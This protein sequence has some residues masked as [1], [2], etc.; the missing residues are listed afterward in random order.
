VHVVHVVTALSPDNGFGGPA[1][2][3][4]DLA[5]GAQAAGHDV[6]VIAAAVGYDTLPTSVQG[7]P[8]AL[9]RGFNPT[10]VLGWASLVAP[11]LPRL[12]RRQLPGA[13]VVHVHLA[14]DVVTLTGALA[15]RRAHVPYL[16]QTHGMIDAAGGRLA[17]AVDAIATR[18][19]V[20]GAREA[21]VLTGDEQAE[22]HALGLPEARIFRFPNG[23]GPP[24]APRSDPASGPVLFLARLH[25]RKGAAAFARAAVRLA[26]LEPGTRFAII[27]PNEG[28]GAAVDRELD[29]ASPEVRARIERIGGVP[30]EEARLRLAEALVYVLPA[31]AEPFGMTVIEAM[32][33]GRPV[34]LAQ[35]SELAPAVRD[36]GAGWTFG[37]AGDHPDLETALGAVLRD[38]GA[39]EQAG[40]RAAA[41]VTERFRIDAVVDQLLEHYEQIVRRP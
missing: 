10:P 2:V 32:S 20:A 27:G 39:I 38:R 12:L 6:L 31:E 1:R 19:A 24:P 3:A 25:P 15:A 9:A 21:L 17:R 14:R 22:L 4:L 5:A 26:A 16:V 37:P 34:V 8:I 13:D 7:V 11:G 33:A 18:H 35:S 36:A 40:V 41:L 23:V 28:D 29:A 30:S